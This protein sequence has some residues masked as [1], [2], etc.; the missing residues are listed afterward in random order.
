MRNQKISDH[1]WKG[2]RD[3]HYGK[4][5]KTV[6]ALGQ[7]SIINLD[8]R[9][10][11]AW[12]F[13]YTG[14]INKADAEFHN[15]L[16]LYPW[17]AGA[18]EGAREVEKEKLKKAS[19]AGYY[20]DIGK[21]TIAHNK[22]MGLAEE[23][24]KWSHAY[25]QMGWINL[26]NQKYD[27]ARIDFQ[28]A[29]EFE[30]T[31]KTA[32]EGLDK[33]Q[34]ITFP[35]IYKAEQL[36]KSG[37]YIGAARLYNDYIESL[38]ENPEMTDTLAHACN[39]LGWSQFWKKQY[40]MAINKFQKTLYHPQLKFDSA[41]G[42]GLSWFQLANYEKAAKYLQIADDIQHN[43]KEI[44]PKLDWSI[45]RS[46]N[47]NKSEAYFQQVLTSNPLRYSAYLG[48][49]WIYYKNQKPDLGVEYFL[50]AISLDPD[51]S[52]TNEFQNMLDG[53]RF[54]WQVYNQLGWAYYHRQR[55]ARALELFRESLDRQ[56]GKSE[57]LKGMGYSLYRLGS[58]SQ[59]ITFLQQSLAINPTPKPVVEQVVKDNAITPFRTKTSVL[60]TI[61]RSYHALGNYQEAISQFN[62]ELKQ[63]PH[64][65]EIY[66]GLGWSNLKLNRMA[67][68]QAA[69]I[70][71]LRYQPLFYSSKKGL[72][73]I[74]QST[75][76]KKLQPVTLS[77]PHTDS[78]PQ[79]P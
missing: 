29:L 47:P 64:W 6:E 42:L 31:N 79:N 28:K 10:G 71:S 15:I 11:L 78:A 26:K 40:Q 57:T 39:G 24:P 46:S 66:D 25:N 54:G 69:F 52:L 53:E 21:Y 7:Q 32:Q 73:E 62:Q 76:M 19:F 35:D 58:F 45:L 34:K 74:K 36:F 65:P 37:D 63:N 5:L 68:A 61:G 72:D 8:G 2:R 9:N 41:K 51:F 60:T 59:A 1:G 3:N 14:Q 38:G 67:E 55:Y 16:R 50:K 18:H 49:G 56:P 12:S 27:N 30:P 33:V 75:I 20:S 48:L 4:A 70:Q 43:H 13:L 23:Y 22:F 17:F 44:I 77:S